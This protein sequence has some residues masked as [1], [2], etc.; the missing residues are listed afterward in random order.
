MT[1]EEFTAGV[2]RLRL[3]GGNKRWFFMS[4][5][6]E[7]CRVDLKSYG[8]TY[9]QIFRINEIDY[10][11]G[12]GMDCKVKKFESYIRESLTRAIAKG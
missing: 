3:A 4:E 2:K 11:G 6:V 12:L 1:I 8:H 7:G 9:L 10:A 5:T